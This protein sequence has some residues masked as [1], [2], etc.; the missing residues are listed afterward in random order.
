LA[1]QPSTVQQA[2]GFAGRVKELAERAKTIRVKRDDTLDI[3][4]PLTE[5]SK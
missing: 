3:E 4:L 5:P 1:R 2:P